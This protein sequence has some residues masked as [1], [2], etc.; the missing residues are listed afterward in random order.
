[1]SKVICYPKS[2]VPDVFEADN[3]YFE[4]FSTPQQKALNIGHVGNQFFKELRK[5]KIKPT[6]IALDFLIISMAI[7]A[8]DKAVLRKNSADGWT[9]QI[10]LTVYLHEADKWIS[11]K[12]K[13]EWMFRFLSGDFW[14]LIIKPLP[15]S[16]VPQNEYPLRDQD[17]VCLLSGGMDSLVGAIDLHESG[18]NP[19]FVSQ[20][21]RGDAEHQREYAAEFGDDNLLQWSNCVSKKGISENSTRSRSLIFFAFALIATCGIKCN[22]QGKKEIFVPENGFIS[23]NVALDSLRMG[24]LSTKTTHPVYM[25]VLQDIWVSLGIDVELVLPYKFKTKGE[26]LTECKNQEL[27]KKYIFGSTSCGKYLRHGFRHCGVC[28]PCMVRRAAFLKAG[29]EDETERGYCIVPLKNS[30]SR[31]VAAAALAS[32]QVKQSGI[33]SLIKGELSFAEESQRKQYAGVV[34]RGI[35]EIGE[36]LKGNNVL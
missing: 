21:V 32:V 6:P 8:A 2:C 23:L 24:T 4:M 29:M 30:N 7:V 9:R 19:L 27:M 17:C 1:M 12:D 26:V 25:K 16:L 18:R 13:L 33:E 34:E 20:I 28:V 35:K 31:D 14:E 10:E 22:G 15:V 36:L 3:Y 5:S 11:V